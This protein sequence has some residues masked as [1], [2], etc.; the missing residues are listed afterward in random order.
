[1]TRL[2]AIDTSTWRAELALVESTDD[3]GPRV[4]AELALEV[5]DSHAQGLIGRIDGLLGLAGWS[6]DTP[7]GYV[8]VRGPGSFTGIR[9]ALGTAR[10]LA[11]A[12]GR[13]CFGVDTLTA[14]AEAHGPAELPRLTVLPA[15]RGEVFGARFDAGS[16][17]PR[18]LDDPW[19][20][21]LDQVPDRAAGSAVL[22]RAAGLDAIAATWLA[23]TA[24]L[25]GG[26]AV[27]GI[28]AAAGRLALLDPDRDLPAVPLYVRSPDAVLPRRR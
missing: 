20:A 13:P 7:D 12:S 23:R 5:R 22:V 17:P 2:L 10:G 3:G 16:S 8:A 14:M 27:R 6:R 28:A 4:V 26:P 11:L 19:L 24:D 15:G 21:A 1:M 25:R 9:V 18:P